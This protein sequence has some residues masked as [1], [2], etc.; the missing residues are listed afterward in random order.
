MLVKKTCQHNWLFKIKPN[1]SN[2]FRLEVWRHLQDISTNYIG[3]RIDSIKLCY[4]NNG[5]NNSVVGIATRYELDGPGIES[6]WGR[7]TQHPS[8]LALGPTQ[9]PVQW[10]PGHSRG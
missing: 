9:P 5:H 1:Y 3:L 7:D 2:I 6:R 8:R 10:V 4:I